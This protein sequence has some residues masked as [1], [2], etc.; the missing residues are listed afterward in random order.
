MVL[1]GVYL[2]NRSAN[3]RSVLADHDEQVL[4]DKSELLI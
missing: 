2:P 1:S 4:G 3:A